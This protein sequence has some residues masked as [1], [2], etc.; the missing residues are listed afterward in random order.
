MTK[1][2]IHIA[3]LL[4]LVS[5]SQGG[6]TQNDSES[7]ISK[8]PLIEPP[9]SVAAGDILRIV[10]PKL[11]SEGY[12]AKLGRTPTIMISHE[13]YDEI[14]A[15]VDINA[16][17]GEY[18]LTLETNKKQL[19]SFS[20]VVPTPGKHAFSEPPKQLSSSGIEKKALLKKLLWSNINPVLPFTLPVQ[21]E[22]ST[23]FGAYFEMNQAPKSKN[24]GRLFNASTLS[25][26]DSVFLTIEEPT[27]IY[28]PSHSVCFLVSFDQD[29]GYTVLLDHGMGLFSEIS[30]LSN[31]TISEQDR[32]PKNALI[33]SFNSDDFVGTD[34]EITSKT[35]Q[36]RTF[37]NKATVNPLNLTKI[38]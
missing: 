38:P 4:F 37:L 35:I 28:A 11:E 13:G 1:N 8:E 32:V 10:S 16:I 20:F 17:P 15:G 7:V 33:A 19:A 24:K 3:V 31:L 6:N 2:Y 21:G 23:T 29:K 22:W 5:F 27:A 14:I 26:V 9:Q 30:G 36:W 34:N 25:R 18:L 12:V